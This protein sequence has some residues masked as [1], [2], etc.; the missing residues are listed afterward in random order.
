MLLESWS[1]FLNLSP[2]NV[3]E[4]FITTREN[5]SPKHSSPQNEGEIF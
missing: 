4:S 3:I 1:M 5:Q 2:I